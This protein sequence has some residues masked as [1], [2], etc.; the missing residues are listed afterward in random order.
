MAMFR[1]MM[2]LRRKIYIKKIQTS[3]INDS[4]HA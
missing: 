2:F 4:T 3:S 1:K